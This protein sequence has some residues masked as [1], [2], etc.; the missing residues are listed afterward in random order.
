MDSARAFLTS[1]GYRIRWAVTWLALLIEAFWTAA[2][3]AV[4]VI[5]ATTCIGLLGIP[6]GVGQVL[7]GIVH[8]GL[9]VVIAL[10]LTWTLI[11]AIRRF[12]MP[13][14]DTVR[15]R[16]ELASGLSHRPLTTLQDRLANSADPRA[17]LL[18]EAFRKQTI[19]ARLPLRA[20]LPRPLLPK[21]D[22][23]GMRA[24]LGMLL[25]LGLVA[26]RDDPTGRLLAA[27]QPDLAGGAAGLAVTFDVWVNPPDYTGLPPVRLAAN[28]SDVVP[29]LPVPQGSQVLAV[30]SGGDGVPVIKANRPDTPSERH[31][32]EI[33]DRDSFRLEL[34]VASDQTLVLDQSGKTLS[35]WQL[36]A[37]PDQPPEIR[38]SEPPGVT[39]R[40]SLKLAFEARDDYGVTKAHATLKRPGHDDVEIVLPVSGAG[41]R[42]V[43]GGSFT[44]LLAH[45][46]AGETVTVVLSAFDD[47]DQSGAS[48]PV[49]MVLPERQFLHPVARAVN[50][51]RKNLLRN[52]DDR[53][54]VAVGALTLAFGP[55]RYGH[56][57]VVFLGL[58]IASARLNLNRDGNDDDSVARL[59]WDTAVHIEDGELMTALERLRDIQQEL[60]DA[61]ASNASDQ[62][63]QALMDQ[64]ESAIQRY[65]EAMAEDAANRPQG[66]VQQSDRT[67]DGHDLQQMM[68]RMRDMA[69]SGA[70]DTARDMLSQLQEMMENLQMGNVGMSAQQQAFQQMMDDLGRLAREQQALMDESFRQQQAMPGDR[71]DDGRAQRRAS[72][73]GMDGPTMSA[74]QLT[75]LQQQLRQRLNRFMRRAAQQLGAVPGEF[76]EAGQSMGEAARALENARPGEAVGPQS[77]AIE[78][79]MDGAQA[80]YNDSREGGEGFNPVQGARRGG[81]LNRDP[82]GRRRPGEGY[83]D[84]GMV[85][86]PTE[87]DVQKARR[88]IIEL[89]RRS[90]E[91][92]RPLL[93]REYI[94]RLLQRF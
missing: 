80:L 52:P 11:V 83:F 57:V 39:A 51:L 21:I 72:P 28:D 41:N 60:Q 35:T 58:K 17:R 46:W 68:D 63:I 23:F 31:A 42:E 8:A 37:V 26:A 74:D 33:I 22:R 10:L 54:Q 91:R 59:L 64:L 90:G 49:E 93:E 29:V 89:Q 94:E 14:R 79:L 92:F 78:A 44:D 43:N 45:P 85:D 38:F 4:A 76:D 18:W 5:L 1:P 66:P 48:D 71:P 34:P 16:L 53:K 87:V 13:G 6:Q 30:V 9:M 50:A 77:D 3:P 32:F 12:R 27:L 69:S 36:V 55:A 20:S 86:L 25:I 19:D 24:G 7:G 15:R 47:L 2:T 82:L 73:S 56:D 67:I 61:L 70:R 81:P 65:L 40:G 75:S 84:D 88:I 62:E